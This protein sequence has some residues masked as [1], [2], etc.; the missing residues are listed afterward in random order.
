[1]KKN[2]NANYDFGMQKDPITP[3]GYGDFA[4]MPKEAKY[5]TFSKDNSYRDGIVNSFTNTLVDTSDIYENQR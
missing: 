3:M 2:K 1:M 5:M 4:N